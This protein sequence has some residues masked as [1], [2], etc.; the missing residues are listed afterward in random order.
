MKSFICTLTLPDGKR[1]VAKARANSLDEE[2]AIEW[3]GFIQG[4]GQIVVGR[5]TVGFLRWYLEARAQQLRAEFDF[6]TEDDSET[7]KQTMPAKP[8]RQGVKTRT[9]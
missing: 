6:R 1:I 8:R 3:T 7:K 2:V 4:L 9:R 5:H